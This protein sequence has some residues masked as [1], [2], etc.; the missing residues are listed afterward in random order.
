METPEPSKKAETEADT[1]L[2]PVQNGVHFAKQL[3]AALTVFLDPSLFEELTRLAKA[4]QTSEQDVFLRLIKLAKLIHDFGLY[5]V[6]TP[7]GN[8][9]GIHIRKTGEVHRVNLEC[10][11]QANHRP[12]QT[13]QTPPTPKKP[14]T[15]LLN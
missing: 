10:P 14:P 3:M 15:S 7:D 9:L 1:N 8:Y 11:A 6:P 5:G 4:M 12:P 2:P 13:P